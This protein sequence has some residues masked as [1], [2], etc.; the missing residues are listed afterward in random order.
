MNFDELGVIESSLDA[1]TPDPDG[2]WTNY[3]MGVM[4]AFEGRGMKLETGL[5]IA[6]RFRTFFFRILRSGYRIYVKGSV[7]F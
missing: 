2:L 1:F 4:W 6:K 5:D 3:P 7:W